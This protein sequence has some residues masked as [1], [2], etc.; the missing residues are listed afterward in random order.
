MIIKN[1]LD[2]C[3]LVVKL[4]ELLMRDIN[5]IYDVLIILS[6]IYSIRDEGVF[7]IPPFI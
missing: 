5:N 2:K 4:F 7:I 3:D 1:T 6:E